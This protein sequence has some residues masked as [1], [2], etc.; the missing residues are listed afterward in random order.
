[1]Q[2]KPPK[3]LPKEVISHWPEVFKDINIDVVP[4]EYL[5]SIRI[6]FADGKLWEIAV[7]TDKT[8]PE[9]LEKSLED[10]FEQYKDHIRNIDFR[11]NTQKVKSD[12]KARTSRFLKFR[13]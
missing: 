10:L 13:K 3:K 6:E 7:N 4:L 5:H 8:P 1:M 9:E 2:K 11:L 12:I